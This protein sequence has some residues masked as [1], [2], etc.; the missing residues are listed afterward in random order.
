MCDFVMTGILRNELV[1]VDEG[2]V[3]YVYGGAVENVCIAAA[4][5]SGPHDGCGSPAKEG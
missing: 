1:V 4:I 3:C 2:L 5:R